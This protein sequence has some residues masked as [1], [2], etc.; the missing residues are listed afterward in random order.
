M[1]NLKKG[2]SSEAC[3]QNHRHRAPILSQGDGFRDVESVRIM[4]DRR[5]KERLATAVV[6]TGGGVT[7]GIMPVRMIRIV[8][9]SLVAVAAEMN[10]R[11][12]RVTLRL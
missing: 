11:S 7:I 3:R 8:V 12:R 1:R 6:I 9:V 10:M 2:R 4:V 5:P